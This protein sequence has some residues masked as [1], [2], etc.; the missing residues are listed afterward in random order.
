V[1]HFTISFSTLKQADGARLTSEIKWPDGPLITPNQPYSPLT[2]GSQL[3]PLSQIDWVFQQQPKAKAGQYQAEI[4]F[5]K[6]LLAH[7]K[8]KFG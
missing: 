8:R 7:K 1:W 5:L 2:Y 3:V 6:Q 4:C